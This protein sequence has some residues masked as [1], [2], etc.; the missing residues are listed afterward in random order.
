MSEKDPRE[1]RASDID[2]ASIHFLKTGHRPYRRF[3]TS[4]D[5]LDLIEPKKWYHR[6]LDRIER[7]LEK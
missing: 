4:I 6:I 7:W 3:N 1:L 2:R 5:P